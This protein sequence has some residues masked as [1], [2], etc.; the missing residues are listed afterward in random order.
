MSGFDWLF[1]TSQGALVLCVAGIVLA[2][3]A[4]F[5]AERF[6]QKSFYRDDET[7]E[8]KEAREKREEAGS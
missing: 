8:E 2:F 3:I 1:S 4:A 7:W 6:L 5:V